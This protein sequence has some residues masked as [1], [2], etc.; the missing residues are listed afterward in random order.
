MD[1]AENLLAKA[2]EKARASG[3]AHAEF[4]VADL[5]DL[6]LPG[7]GFDAVACDFGV[8]F[9]PDIAA[10]IRALWRQVRPGGRLAVPTWGQDLWEP[11]TSSFWS[12]VRAVR[13]DLYRGY[14][15]CDRIDRPET[16][17][18][19]FEEA[20][21]PHVRIEVERGSH[22]LPT[23]ESWWATVMG[24]GF[25]ATVDRLSPREVEA[26]REATLSFLR[27]HRVTSVPSS[28]LYAL[29]AK[30]E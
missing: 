28:V 11:A 17:R 12:A 4:R 8:F 13:S 24:S 6:N 9:V 27:E 7:A 18:A 21:V 19:L 20:G 10:G 30:A 1:I 2:R 29:A 23:P 22:P 16:L 26:V 15:P 3:L 25:R 14:Q 5:L